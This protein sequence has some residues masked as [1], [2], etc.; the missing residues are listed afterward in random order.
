MTDHIETAI[1][2]TTETGVITIPPAAAIAVLSLATYG[3]V[4]LTRKVVGKAK[5]LIADRKA[6]KAV[7]NVE[8]RRSEA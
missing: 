6:K 5:M 1:E 3:G 7:E 8:P 2:A 4:D